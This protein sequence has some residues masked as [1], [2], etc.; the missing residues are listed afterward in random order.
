M[1]DFAARLL[2]AVALALSMYLVI[3]LG[4][5]FY[6]KYYQ[7]ETAESDCTAS[8]R[9]KTFVTSLYLQD[10]SKGIPKRYAGKVNSLL[11]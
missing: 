3:W 2:S 9:G 8:E 7:G 5:C 6:L 11:R 4:F 10:K 1:A